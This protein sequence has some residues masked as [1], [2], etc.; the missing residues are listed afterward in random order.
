[1]VYLDVFGAHTSRIV[2]L[3]R[4]PFLKKPNLPSKAANDFSKTNSALRKP[5]LP[6]TAVA[7]SQRIWRSAV[8]EPSPSSPPRHTGTV[9]SS[10]IKDPSL[11]APQGHSSRK[12]PL[13]TE[14]IQHAPR[15]HYGAKNAP[16]RGS[17]LHPHRVDP[18][19][20]D[21]LN[22]LEQEHAP[23]GFWNRILGVNPQGR[24]ENRKFSSNGSD[25]SLSKA[26]N[27]KQYQRFKLNHRDPA[28][29]KTPVR[30]P[31]LPRL[32]GIQA[33]SE[34][35]FFRHQKHIALAATSVSTA[36]RAIKQMAEVLERA[37]EEEN[38][39]NQDM[40]NTQKLT[41]RLTQLRYSKIRVANILRNTA[42]P[43][44]AHGVKFLAKIFGDFTQ[45]KSFFINTQ[46][47]RY[48]N[49]TSLINYL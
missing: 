14:C 5:D 15:R 29:F 47:T 22:T 12:T 2:I 4:D 37:D 8:Q 7:R 38:W 25:K 30:N 48:S 41:K 17:T 39:V 21:V 16:V 31:I 10:S 34:S 9:S 26:F 13:D 6:V 20:V 49:I 46:H 45:S 42:L 18:N 19:K 36:L 27:L 1:M 43:M 28:G 33:K 35:S 3:A 40:N 24:R 32:R 44:A 23:H 11:P